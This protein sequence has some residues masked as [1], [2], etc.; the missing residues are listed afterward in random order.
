MAGFPTTL[1]RPQHPNVKRLARVFA[2]LMGVMVGGVGLCAQAA[3]DVPRATLDRPLV[4]TQ[5]P[6]GTTLE[7]TDSASGAT[8]R[9]PLGEGAG[10]VIVSPDGARRVLSRGFHSA[11]DPDVSFDGRRVLFAGKPAARDPWNV[12]EIAADGSNLRQ[13]TRG[14]GDCRSPGYQSTYYE[15]T[16]KDPWYQVTFV[17]TDPAVVN[18][19]GGA[20]VSSLYSCKLDGTWLRRLTYNLSSDFDPNIAWDGRLLYAS[21]QR[22]GFENG[23]LGR[24]RL[25][26]VNTDGADCAALVGESGKRIQHMPCTTIGGLAV[27]V[28]ADRAPW[29]G[30]GT[31]ACVQLRRPFHTYRPLTRESDGLFHSPSP[32]PDGRIL[33]SRRPADGSATHGVFCLDPASGRLERVFDDPQ[34]HDVQARLLAPRAEPDGRSSSMDPSDPRG[35]LYCLDVY[36]SDLKGRH[37][38]SPGTIK[39]VRVLEGLPRPA[40]SAE[41]AIGTAQLAPRRILA[42]VPIQEDFE[43]RG[44]KKVLSAGSFNVEVPANTPIQLQLLDDQGIA[45]RSCTW[46][47]VRNHQAQ[48]CIGCHEDGELT[49]TNWQVAALWK[50]SVEAC[51]PPA[52]RVAVDFRRQIVPL[53]AA[54]CITCHDPKGSPPNLA[55]ERG[56]A[57]AGGGGGEEGAARKLYQAL[58]AADKAG[59]E[60]SPYGKYVHPGRARTSPLVWHLFGR[61]TSYPWDGAAA[62]RAAKPIPPGQAAPLAE[63]DR[64]R[65]VRWIDLGALWDHVP[66]QAAL[67][68]NPGGGARA[69]R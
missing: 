42:E 1:T 30:A 24:V 57:G 2:L 32:L 61:N 5:L 37:R 9:G 8:L 12:Y 28:E 52:E 53:V 34:Y 45:M 47:W 21:W 14:L 36:T 46:V 10:I 13:I 19:Y 20:P 59:S 63:E 33:V 26:G 54:R 3:P 64:Q 39:K 41:A 25:F 58:L 43:D 17:R 38:M 18:E 11:A 29:D 56:G 55:F 35:K 48:G 16:E 60:A 69:G 49:P 31:L 4:V 66:P 65:F 27:F 23:L 22:P 7:R 6:A 67:P 15:I 50:P 51:P 44:G 62:G 68:G 40:G